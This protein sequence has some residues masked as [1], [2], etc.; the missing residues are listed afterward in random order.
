MSLGLLGDVEMRLDG[1]P[2][3]LGHARQR[4]VLAVLAME[5]GRPLPTE[6]L[7]DHVWGEHVPGRAQSALRTYVSHL[8]RALDPAGVTIE[9]R[10]IGY[11]LDIAPDAVDVNRFGELATRARREDDPLRAVALAEEA[12][13]LWRGE[14]LAELDTPWAVATRERLNR[15]RSSLD[16]DRVDWALAL[17][18]HGELLPDLFA[19]A[20]EDGLNERAAGQLMLALYRCGRQADALDQYRLVRQRLAEDLG[21]DPTPA[22][23][24]LHQRV[25]TSDP[26]L[27]APVAATPRP[28]AATAP[29]PRQLPVPPRLFTGR[30]E[31]LATLLAALAAPED[32]TVVVVISGA[33]G[34]G[35]TW[36]ALHGAHRHADRF[37][38]GQLFADLKGFG[39][40]GSPLP[41]TVVVR[42]FLVALGVD[43]DRLPADPDAQVALFRSTVADKRVL[44]VLDNA[45]DTAQVTSLL[46][47]G[48]NCAVLVTSRNRLSGLV[49]TH[50]AHHLALDVLTDDE[51]RALLTRRLG[52]ARVAAEPGAVA[53]LI[54][55]CGGFPLALGVIAARAYGEPHIP[56]AEFAAELRDLGLDALADPDPAASLPSVLSWSHRA[57]TD[58]QAALFSLLGLAPGADLGLHAAANLAGLPTGRARAQLRVLEQASLIGHDAPGRY[59]MHDL[60]RAHAVERAPLA[61]PDSRDAL[62]RL[63]DYYRHTAA[64]AVDLLYPAEKH[65]R[66]ATTAF[67]GPAPSLTT[68][69]AAR[70]WLDAEHDNLVAVAAH[71]ADHGLYEYA[72][73]LAGTV[74]HYLYVTGQLPA[75]LA[76]CGHGLRAAHAAGNRVWEARIM[77]NTGTTH[78]RGGRGAAVEHLHR[79]LEIVRETGDTATEAQARN[80]LG[81]ELFQD[82]KSGE[83]LDHMRRALEL[84][85]DLGDHGVVGRVL[86]NMGAVYYRQGRYEELLVLLREALELARSVGNRVIEARVL[87]NIGVVHVERRDHVRALASLEQ[88]ITIHRETGN[89]T[90]EGIALINTASARHYAGDHEHAYRDILA[91]LT[92]LRPTGDR[93]AVESALNSAGEVAL[94]LDR[95]DEA[96]GFLHEALARSQES[97]NRFN[98]ARGQAALG[99]VFLARDDPAE[100]KRLWRRSLATLV[101]LGAAEADQVAKRLADL[102]EPV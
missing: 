13:A 87:G 23:Q 45:V 77:L 4:S 85:R 48:G 57:L 60:V 47:G 73:H 9:R 15:E 29:V 42:G 38:D 36:L 90:G 58:Q 50:G 8:R 69:E 46:P 92:T 35:K 28:V 1:V 86:N 94:A 14:P 22:L 99:D 32:G 80:M 76:L 5:A 25:L 11:V 27:A 64:V 24:A 41:P 83:A 66:P 91:A 93:S 37:P 68:A 19:R 97:G 33:G 52:T 20:A 75:A 70:A 79:C 34:I 67:D 51:A 31:Q 82:G 100:A 7:V 88:A 26:T 84:A 102:G 18:R 16:A 101:E 12:L 44:F 49:T 40:E 96:A 3:P 81:W 98:H 63:A 61:S 21:A 2:V 62:T 71:A 56:L 17:G 74:W 54:G 78:S 10:G 39:P 30:D 65:H 89:R 6:R 53:D 55:L 95:P 72:V 59:R 43:A